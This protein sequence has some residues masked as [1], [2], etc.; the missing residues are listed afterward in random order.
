MDT[1]SLAQGVSTLL[2][3]Y[4][5]LQPLQFTVQIHVMPQWWQHIYV[6]VPSTVK[7]VSRVSIAT[8]Y[9]LDCSGSFEPWRRARSSTRIHTGPGVH[10]I[11][12]KTVTRSSPGV[13]GMGHG[14]DRE[15]EETWVT[16]HKVEDKGIEYY[17]AVHKRN[18]SIVWFLTICLHCM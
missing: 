13:Q 15:V 8:C 17:V 6:R 2:L 18:M 14:I 7:R 12:Y 3:L 9:R 10:P 5:V 4:V 16:L 1:I 11:V